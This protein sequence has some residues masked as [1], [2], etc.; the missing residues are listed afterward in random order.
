MYARQDLKEDTYLIDRFFP[1]NIFKCVSEYQSILQCHWHEHV[2]IIYL[3]C[4]HAVFNIGSHEIEAIPGDILFVNSGLLHSGYSVDNT[5]VEFDAIVFNKSMLASQLPDPNHMKHVSP[6]MDDRLSF[7]C[8][9]AVDDPHYPFLR[10]YV[11]KIREEL[12]EK[13]HGYEVAVKAYLHLLTISVFRL[14]HTPDLPPSDPE[15]NRRN[16]D[17]ISKLMP[18]LE[19]HFSEKLTVAQAAYILNL[20]VYHFCRIFK[21]ITGRTFI[22]FLNLYRVNQA[23][24]LLRSSDL[25]I[26]EIA[27]Q[28]G[29]CNINYFDKKF[30]QYKRYSPSSCRRQV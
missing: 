6:F 25:P 5:R 23:E 30:K 17:K 15:I 12:R 21:K 16:V 3:E 2:E 27:E 10:E 13:K 8:R 19:Q 11:M 29:F 22:E 20:S 18:F 26:T 9:I 7:P 28:V 4:G 14:Y 1:M 24:K